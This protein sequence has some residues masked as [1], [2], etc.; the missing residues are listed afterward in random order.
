MRKFLFL[1]LTLLA[2]CTARAGISVSAAW[3]RALP[4]GVANTAAYMTLHNT[5]ATD[6]ELLGAAS[7]VAGKVELH[8]TMNHDG[9]MHMMHVRSVVIPAGG[10]LKLESGGLHLMLMQLRAMPAAG[11]EV[12]LQLRFSDGSELLV[13]AP[14]RSVLD[15]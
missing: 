11:T 14:V 4:P 1:L 7:S 9:M 15:E 8:E 13:R 12:E 6:V 5:G 3:V 2:A 10:E